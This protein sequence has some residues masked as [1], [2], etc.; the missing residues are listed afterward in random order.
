MLSFS[1]TKERE[2]L[3]VKQR[4]VRRRVVGRW[5]RS[6][7]PAIVRLNGVTRGNVWLRGNKPTTVNHTKSTNDV[8]RGHMAMPPYP[9]IFLNQ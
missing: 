5:Q 6:G 7:R 9:R 1:S 3:L 2:R 8:I 4:Q